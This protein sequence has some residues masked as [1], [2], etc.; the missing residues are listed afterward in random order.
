[1]TPYFRRYLSTSKMFKTRPAS[2]K[3]AD[4]NFFAWFFILVPSMCSDKENTVSSTPLDGTAIPST[5]L[6]GGTKDTKTT[7]ACHSHFQ[8]ENIERLWDHV[9]LCMFWKPQRKCF[10]T[11]PLPINTASE[12]P[13]FKTSVLRFLQPCRLSPVCSGE[14]WEMESNDRTQEQTLVCSESQLE[15]VEEPEEW[16]S[17]Y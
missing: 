15:R 7:C 3:Y 17:T 14:L 1:M 9:V 6:V 16:T 10:K 5:F 8:C 12:K 4:H 2:S 11:N 13:S